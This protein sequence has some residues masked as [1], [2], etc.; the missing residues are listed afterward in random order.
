M[1]DSVAGDGTRSPGE[2]VSWTVRHEIR[3]MD[4]LAGLPS[5]MGWCEALL[6]SEVAQADR[7]DALNAEAACRIFGR[8]ERFLQTRNS[9]AG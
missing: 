6:W 9:S 8:R 3:S 1:P 5:R 2:A 4:R 7:A